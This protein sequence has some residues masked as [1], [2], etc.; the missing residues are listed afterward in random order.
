LNWTST[1]NVGINTASPKAN[2]HVKNGSTSLSSSTVTYSSTTAQ[3]LILDQQTATNNNGSVV[4]FNNDDLFAAIASGRPSI[5]NWGTDLRFY[6]HPDP[7]TNQ[8]DVTERM[9]ITSAG[10]VGI[11][12]TSPS[13]K[14]QIQGSSDSGIRLTDSSGN[15]RALLN[16]S[17][18]QH[19]EFTLFNNSGNA[20][21]YLGGGAGSNYVM[22]QG[23]NFLIGTT[24]SSGIGTGSSVNQGVEIGSGLISIQT[25][26]NS[27][28]Y[29]S[30]ATGYTSGDFTAHFVNSA[31]VGGISTNGSATNYATASDYR[32]KQ[33]LKDFEGIN[34]INKIKTYD[35]EWKVDNTRM[36][37]IIAHELQEILP[38]AV[39]GEKD[40]ERMQAVDYS[41]LVPILIKAIQELKTEIDS[42]KNQIK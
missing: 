2:L 18:V 34:L 19:G 38:Y 4:W 39:T 31:Y 33:D 12:T 17:G 14:L 32:L 30:K 6:T 1:G 42:L 37:G 16:P 23:G 9:R 25:N 24:S 40:A 15:T 36:F 3:G 20:T 41:K 7:T 28:N 26:N 8:L 27:N 5:S 29:W 35:Y 10:N 13:H 11:G 21:T 22:A